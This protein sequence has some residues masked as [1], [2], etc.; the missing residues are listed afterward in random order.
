MWFRETQ[1][2]RALA[3]PLKRKLLREQQ[4]DEE[5]KQKGAELLRKVLA[6]FAR[7]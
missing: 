5:I 7:K 3:L 1:R 2:E 4:I 6:C